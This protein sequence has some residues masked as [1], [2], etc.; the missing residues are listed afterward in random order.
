MASS[1]SSPPL[2]SLII[3]P[4]RPVL[5][6][7]HS[8]LFPSAKSGSIAAAGVG[9]RL[10]R[11]PDNGRRRGGGFPCFSYNANNKNPIPSDKS[12]DEWPILRRWDV[13]WEWQTVVLTMD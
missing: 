5:L 13:P 12:L 4:C 2:L 1:S 10:L 8:K 6:S 3:L 9:Q 7:R 11:W